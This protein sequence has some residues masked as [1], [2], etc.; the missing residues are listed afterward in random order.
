MNI[1]YVYLRVRGT[2]DKRIPGLPLVNRLFSLETR[3]PLWSQYTQSGNWGWARHL[4]F[5]GS[6]TLSPLEWRWLG[7]GERDH[8]QPLDAWNGV[9]SGPSDKVQSSWPF[10]SLS[11]YCPDSAVRA[12]APG[13]RSW[14]QVTRATTQ[15]GK[16]S[17]ANSTRARILSC[18]LNLPGA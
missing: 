17:I 1:S 7:E 10:G 16:S 5:W 9:A 3:I 6:L 15:S 14:R 13:E 11:G 4:R 12:A 8:L 18:T 2:K